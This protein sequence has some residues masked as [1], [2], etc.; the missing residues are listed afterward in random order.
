MNTFIIAKHFIL[1]PFSLSLALT[2][3][4]PPIIFKAL[5]QDVQHFNLISILQSRLCLFDHM[6]D[7]IA[8]NTRPYFAHLLLFVSLWFYSQY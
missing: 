3:N 4:S 7:M 8:I 1:S 6:L 2:A 5:S